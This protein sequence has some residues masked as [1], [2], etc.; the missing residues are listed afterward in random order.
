MVHISG[1][2]LWLGRPD[3]AIDSARI[4]LS[5]AQH[6]DLSR[7]LVLALALRGDADEAE[8][9]ANAT[10]RT[11]D[12]LLLAQSMLAAIR[13]DSE[14]AGRYEE[15]YLGRYGPNDRE[16]LVL[17]AVRGNRG[18]ANRLAAEIDRRPF[19]HVVLLQAIYNC[20]CGAPF[21]LEATPVFASML[22]ASGLGWPPAR[23]YDLPLKDG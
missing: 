12:E 6:P 23:P 15:S 1:A 22:A 4:S 21:D 19:G 9:T 8:S 5:K 10:I 2:L 16:S 13:G 18:E 11:E 7:H 20:L 14:A 17:E 3:D